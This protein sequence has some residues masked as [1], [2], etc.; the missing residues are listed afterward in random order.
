VQKDCQTRKLNKED[1]MEKAD[2]GW[3]M[4]RQV[5]AGTTSPG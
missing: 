3:L 2:K 1:A 4:I 5:W